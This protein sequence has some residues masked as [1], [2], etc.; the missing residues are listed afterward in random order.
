[1]TNF[2]SN[3]IFLKLEDVTFIPL[4]KKKYLSI[5]YRNAKF[6]CTFIKQFVCELLKISMKLCLLNL[7]QIFLFFLVLV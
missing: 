5:N 7:K 4:N 6:K 1:M 2:F 3:S